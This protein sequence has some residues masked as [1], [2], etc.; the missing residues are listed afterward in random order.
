[1]K[2]CLAI[3]A[4]IAAFFFGC[5]PSADY[6][7]IREEVVQLHDS[8]MMDTEIAY[9]NKR[10]LDT[11]SGKL[12]SLKKLNPAL[13]TIKELQLITG[14]RLKLDTAEAEMEDWMHKFEVEKGDKS[15]DEAVAYFSREKAKIKAIDSLYGVV[16]K[17][18]GEYLQKVKK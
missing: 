16:L 14:L 11:L 6:K 10:Q 17:E 4:A 9:R 5:K 13:D 3:T 2:K 15:D 7:T 1:M 8:V 18:S 12:D